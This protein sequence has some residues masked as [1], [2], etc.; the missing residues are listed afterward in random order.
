MKFIDAHSDTASVM[1]DSKKGLKNNGLHFDLDRVPANHTQILAA[2]IAPKYHSAPMDRF[3]AIVENLKDV[4]SKTDGI[5]LCLD[6]EMREKVIAEG[7]TAAFLSLEGAELIK[8]VADVETIYNA[9][10][11][12]VSLTWNGA[13]Q[14]A[15]GVDSGERLSVLG[16]R[17]I[18]AMCEKGIIVDVSHL[19]EQSFWDVLRV[20][21]WPLVAT[22]SCSKSV[23]NHKRNLTDEQF[24]AICSRGG[25]VGINFYPKFLN[26]RRKAYIKNILKH[27]DHFLSLGGENHIGLGSDFDG[28]DCLPQDLSG[29]GDMN[30]LVDAMRSHGY[31][32]ELIE[33]IC[34][35]NFERILRLV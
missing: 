35:K 34:Y 23:F 4:I 9:G 33:K 12:I 16:R 29:V 1:L 20:N 19:N 13:N 30:V 14:L 17:V 32:E 28:V 22:H 6:N 10:V 18:E 24:N 27:I 2:Y 11:R 15:G 5:E 3:M 8:S 7:K 31:S 21:K 26:G 25:V